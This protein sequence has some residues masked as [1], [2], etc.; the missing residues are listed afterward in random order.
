MN[1]NN[2]IFQKISGEKN[3]IIKSEAQYGG[4]SG[5]KSGFDN[6]LLQTLKSDISGV[7]GREAR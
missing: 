3:S 5:W 2:F 7:I 1:I 4:Q 6:R